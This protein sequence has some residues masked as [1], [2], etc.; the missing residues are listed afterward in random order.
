MLFTQL[1]NFPAKNN[2]EIDLPLLWIFF[3]ILLV[4]P[5]CNSYFYM[6]RNICFALTYLSLYIN[7]RRKK[8]DITEWKWNT[9]DGLDMYSKAW[10]SSGEGKGVVCLIHGLGEHIGR[11][12][13]DGETMAESGYIL[14]GFDQR[15]FRKSG[16]RRGHTP[17]LEAYFDDIDLF[18]AEIAQRY[19]DQPRFLYGYSMG[20]ILVLAYTPIRKPQLAGVIAT[21]PGLKTMIQE[22]K[23]KVFL[24]KLLGKVLPTL[25]LNNGL[26]AQ[27][28]SRDP[29]VADEYLNDPLTH[30]S[31]TTAFGK[32]ML[33][34][35][36]LVFENAPR[37]PLPLLIMHGTKDEIAY[38]SSSTIFA[39][40]APKDKVTLKL[41]DG[42]KHELHN[43]PDKAEVFKVMIN[44]LDNRL[45]DK[46][47]I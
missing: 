36:D 1:N 33:R 37:F 32:T 47:Q 7:K 43:D 2:K 39:E 17:S 18:L 6:N 46:I 27:M 3:I 16:G 22:Q 25:T 45:A 34:A 10:L 8:M 15:G 19:P 20:G 4:S 26:D 13:I 5:L 44:W 12:Q 42:F 29:R 21:G 35:I 14:A 38:P 11:Y 30:S 24:S 41:W 9:S 40:L 28:L 31:I 23:L